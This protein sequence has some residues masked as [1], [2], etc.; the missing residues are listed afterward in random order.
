MKSMCDPIVLKRWS[1]RSSLLLV[2]ILVLL[3]TRFASLAAGG[4]NL[5]LSFGSGGKIVT[6]EQGGP[7]IFSAMVIQPD[8][9]IVAGGGGGLNRDFTLIRYNA[10]GSLDPSFGAGGIAEAAFGVSADQITAI[11]LRADGKI[12]AVGLTVAQ[13]TS[14]FAL[15]LFNSNGSLDTSFGTDG[16]ATTDVSGAGVSDSVCGAAIQADGKILVGGSSITNGTGLDFVLVRYNSDGS[17]DA[18][19]GAGGK[20]TTDFAN[21]NDNALAMVFQ[22]DGKVILAGTTQI[23]NQGLSQGTAFALV[24]YNTDGSPDTTFGAGGKVITKFLNQQGRSSGQANALTLQSD[25]KIVAGGIASPND[26][27]DFA[28]ARYNTDGSLDA[29]LGSGGLVTTD[30]GS[31][32]DTV[33]G[34]AVRPDGKIVAAGSRD[35]DVGSI[36]RGDFAL[37]R[38]N[39]DG[40]LDA[41][42]GNSGRAI[43]DF[44]GMEDQAAAVAIQSDGKIVVAGFTVTGATPAGAIITQFALARYCGDQPDAAQVQPANQ[45]TCAGSSANFTAVVAGNPSLQWQ[46]SADGGATFTDIPGQTGTT[47]SFIASGSQDG[48]RYRVVLAGCGGQVVPSNT[49]TLAVNTAP[50]V[51]SNPVNQFGSIGAQVTFTSAASGNPAPLIQWQSSTDGGSTFTNIP[52]ATSSSLTVTVTA[53]QALYR[54]VFS[55]QC[56]NSI[57]LPA[58]LVPFDKCLK[59]DHN[60]AFVQLNSTTGD[61]LIT[62]CG[63]GPFN[64]RGV[65]V[66]SVANL[67]LTISDV[68]SDRNIKITST[69]GRSNGTANITIFPAPGVT[70]TLLI[71][72]TNP[73]P[74]C[75]CG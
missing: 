32:S 42:F 53:A 55:N 8:G 15:A 65:G 7:N 35:L 2:L 61:Y 34:L 21:S 46:V 67:T 31:D 64:L 70:K 71:V 6:T 54:A 26:V 57:S 11:A 72:D 47:L 37:A 10:D 68:G 39:T 43:T 24:R 14:D 25:G 19:F 40:S 44:G 33:A 51:T 12:L 27:Q 69:V 17:L 38:Y 75:A 59:D 52:G 18:T 29:S 60:A 49:A 9:K 41:S 1:R 74:V 13:G 22:P 50:R 36:T 48:S 16:K 56:G 45:T 63:P 23:L 3:M 66:V 20:V 30:M 5:D 62:E 4:G 73:H 28:L 58:R